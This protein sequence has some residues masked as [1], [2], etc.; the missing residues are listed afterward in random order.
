[1][2]ISPSSKY[3]VI[4]IGAGPAG[5]SAAVELAKAGHDVTV[6]E[7]SE[8]VG[9]L[10]ASFKLWEQ[11]V[12][13]G[14]HRFFSQNKRVNQFWLHFAGENFR[15]VKRIT[16]IFYA[17]KFFSYPLKPIEAFLRLGLIE[18]LRS[19]VSYFI[20]KLKS[21]KTPILN[22]EDWIIDNFGQRLFQL[23]FKTYS[24]K[25]WGIS[26][27]EIDANFAA[28][29]IK[30]FSLGQAILQS[31]KLSKQKHK[32]L[33]EEFNYPTQGTGMIYE[34]M[35]NEIRSHGGR[36]QIGTKVVSILTNE[37]NVTGV[38][39]SN[40]EDYYADQVI[41]TMPL[42]Q[43]VSSLPEPP[44]EVKKAIESL[45]YRNTILVYLELDS[46]NCFPDQWIYTHCQNVSFGRI[47]NFRNWVP[48]LYGSQKTSILTLEYWC[49]H[50]E[51]LWLKSDEELETL[52]KADMAK[53]EMFEGIPILNAKVIRISKSYPIYRTGYQKHVA[54]IQSFLEEF[55][56]LHAIGRYGSFKYNNQDHS[57]YMGLLA[58]DNI[59]LGTKHSLWDVNSDYDSYQES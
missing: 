3:K 29:R 55:S 51:A 31:L 57:I 53:I 10:C 30:K 17:N 47:T 40:G 38:H 4:V 1:M 41:S 34:N 56:G 18:S 28:Q 7:S 12:D 59:H 8:R 37:K 50:D 42:T 36:I 6:L 14:P 24:E 9:G 26:C 48:E 46:E 43:M 11:T 2:S 35:A 20:E 27:T 49:N 39:C 15:K 25:L 52:A 33:L 44:D 13:L 21:K 22:F 32:T 45:H 19:I 5:L 58:A 23:F 54:C 16:H